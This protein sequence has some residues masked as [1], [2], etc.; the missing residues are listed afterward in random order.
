[1]ECLY[2]ERYEKKNSKKKPKGYY[3]ETIA[4]IITPPGEGGIGA[5]RISGKSSNQII[6]K[7]FRPSGQDLSI[8]KP[9]VMYYGSIKDSK[10]N[11]IDEVTTVSMPAGKSYT[12]Q[13]Q[14]EIFCHGGQFV[15]KQILQEI[16]R[17]D[18]R[19]AEPGEFTRR[20]FLAGRIDLTKAEAV[21]DLIASRT[22]YS[23]RSARD[24]LL[25][26][27]SQYIGNLRDK[28]VQLMAEIEAAIDYP[29]ENL[30]IA[31]KENL[32]K[33]AEYLISNIKDLIDSYRSGKIIREGYKIAIA[34]RPNAGKSSLFN[35]LLNQSRA[36]VT[37]TPGTTRDYLTEWV[38]LSGMA[39]SLTDTAGFRKPDSA[40][41]RSGQVFAEREMKK[42]DLVIWMV[43]ISKKNWK[44]AL[45]SD[46][47]KIN[48]F[49]NVLIV[50]NK[51]DL[52]NRNKT[53]D[54]SIIIKSL[55]IHTL[56]LSCKTKAGFKLLINGLNDSIN[57]NMPDLTDQLVVTSERH[58]RKLAGS[59]KYL[60]NVHR[61]IL[62]NISPELIAFD[63]RQAV[64]EIDEITGRVYTEEILDSIFS[65]F[66]IGK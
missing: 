8:F 39:V 14:A 9:F 55:N 64:D 49:K 63:I 4:S 7:I 2:L 52:V 27:L 24:N 28:A 45:E 29:E 16:F 1:M 42:A 48:R 25:G 44:S 33:S 40:I 38:E 26:E 47:K 19:P 53:R 66:C 43:D 41:E 17:H 15:L 65:R 11:V 62:N 32:L 51:T 50:L 35:L 31:E 3:E 54:I 12:G 57:E 36:I 60:K 30:E 21:A 56:F 58:K 46:L 22:E 13:D 23:Y 37:P 10:G 61:G 5:I 59:L 6:K 20:A 18:V 34:G